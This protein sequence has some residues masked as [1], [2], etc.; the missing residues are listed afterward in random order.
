M[1]MKVIR[2][3]KDLE[4][5]RMYWFRLRPEPISDKDKGVLLAWTEEP[6]LLT[7]Q[8]NVSNNSKFVRQNWWMGGV[9]LSEP[10]HDDYFTGFAEAYG[11]IPIPEPDFGSRYNEKE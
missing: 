2:N 9:N 5:G 10:A 1:S 7:V 11:P 8:K 4:V 3:A 6:I